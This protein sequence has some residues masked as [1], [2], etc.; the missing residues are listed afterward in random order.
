MQKTNSADG[1]IP[2]EDRNGCSRRAFLGKA[3]AAASL[4]IVPRHV[5]GGAGQVASDGKIIAAGNGRMF[6]ASAVSDNDSNDGLSQRA[7]WRSLDKVNAA[8]LRPG[9]K[10]FFKR[11]DTWRGQLV[12]QSGKEGA[13]I[14]Y[15]ANG[16]DDKPVL[17]GSYV[18]VWGQKQEKTHTWYGMFLPEGNRLGAVDAMA[19]AW[20]GRW[21]ADRCPQ[22]GPDKITVRLAQFPKGH[23]ANVSLIDERL[24]CTVDVTDPENDPLVIKRDLRPDVADNPTP[25]GDREPPVASIRIKAEF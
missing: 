12:P 19:M 2:R 9:D 13:P 14:T 6:H 25:G 1:T 4:T 10:V 3:L 22:I 16:N 24:E 5:L 11:G 15:A 21:P 8:E 20:T 18:F 7:P 17:L 23:P